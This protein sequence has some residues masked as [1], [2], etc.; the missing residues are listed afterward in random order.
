M[1][2]ITEP[3]PAKAAYLVHRL[4]LAL[5]DQ[6]VANFDHLGGL[7]GYS[8]VEDTE[9]YLA[10]A[11][12][13]GATI[14]EWNTVDRDGRPLRVVRVTD[15]DGDADIYVT[16]AWDTRTPQQRERAD[17]ARAVAQYETAAKHARQLA[18]A[19]EAGTLSA[20]DAE[21]IANAEDLMAAARAKLSAAGR[22]D[23]IGEGR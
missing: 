22:L 4:E 14:E 16:S 17:L 12:A 10:K 21:S 11:R 3:L 1:T 2:L 15:T 9:N 6:T 18:A 19:A 20:L 13:K 5:A 23:L 8:T 7:W